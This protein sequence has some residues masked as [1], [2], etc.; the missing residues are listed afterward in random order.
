MA[1]SVL[2]GRKEIDSVEKR[3]RR[4]RESRGNE[5][6]SGKRRNELGV[7]DCGQVRASQRCGDLGLGEAGVAPESPNPLTEFGHSRRPRTEG[8][9]FSDS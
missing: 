5:H 8:V 9:M 1:G 7:L 4:R 6:E 2:A 3:C